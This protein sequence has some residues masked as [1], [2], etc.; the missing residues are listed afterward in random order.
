MRK[1]FKAIYLS[2]VIR[3]TVLFTKRRN[4]RW[5]YTTAGENTMK[6]NTTTK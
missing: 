6:L 1:L 2:T 3:F 4:L 5:T